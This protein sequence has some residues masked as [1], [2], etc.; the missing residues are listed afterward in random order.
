MS[1]PFYSPPS[2]N[3]AVLGELLHSVSQPLTTL[4]CSLELSLDDAAERQQQAV[5]AALEQA[6]NVIAMIQL[7][8]EYLDA[9]EEEAKGSAVPVFRLLNSVIEELS[10]LAAIRDVRLRVA[11]TCSAE[12]PGD[13]WRVRKA[14][15]YLIATIVE[16]QPA[17]N[18]VWLRLEERAT[19]IVV[20]A[21]GERREATE[22]NPHKTHSPET[23]SNQA[24]LEEPLDPPRA[25]DNS[26]RMTME[27]VRLAISAR[28]LENAGAALTF[29]ED[30]AEVVVRIPRRRSSRA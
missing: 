9:E 6:E 25:I 11:G 10:P 14:L 22:A 21:R 2:G 12:L 4:R 17:G 8:R 5:T 3:R 19:D 16:R 1:A 30:A 26:L 18:E 15:G 23:N 13:E 7:M 29:G 20:R 27:R 24:V 28:V